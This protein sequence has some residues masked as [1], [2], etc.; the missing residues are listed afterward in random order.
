MLRLRADLAWPTA[1]LDDS[2]PPE[3]GSEKHPALEGLPG[4]DHLIPKV[5]YTDTTL[6]KALR[7]LLPAPSG[8]QGK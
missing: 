8:T 7:A 6:E 3:V 4:M 1:G 5:V 2:L